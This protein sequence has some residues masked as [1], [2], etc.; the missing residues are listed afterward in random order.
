LKPLIQASKGFWGETRY[1]AEDIAKGVY[2]DPK[3]DHI[4]PIVAVSAEKGALVD[5][6]VPINSA[7]LLVVGSAAFLSNETLRDANANANMD[8]VLNGL[9]WLLDREKIIGIAPKTVR[10]LSVNL[11]D[12]QMSSIFLLVILGIPGTA[13]AIGIAVWLKRRR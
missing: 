5:A 8:F 12:S 2:F 11:A 10:N 3:E 7:R 6:I 4:N 13:A 1:G 9:N